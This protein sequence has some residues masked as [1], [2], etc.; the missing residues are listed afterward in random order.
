MQYFTSYQL[1]HQ[2][3]C[4][5][6]D[7]HHELVGL[8]IM[9]VANN[10][11][12]DWIVL[13]FL[14]AVWLPLGI[15]LLGQSSD[16][17]QILSRKKTNDLQ[18]A[19]IQPE[20][21]CN[22]ILCKVHWFCRLLWNTWICCVRCGTTWRPQV[23]TKVQERFEVPTDNWPQRK[24]KITTKLLYLV[25]HYKLN[26]FKKWFQ[27]SESFENPHESFGCGFL[28]VLFNVMSRG[29]TGALGLVP[30]GMQPNG[31]RLLGWLG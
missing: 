22:R 25:G 29:I 3:F 13:W 6:S 8:L 21:S 4:G 16:Q 18:K 31:T 14:E 2:I 10:L 9:E 30:T 27:E 20:V 15:N 11:H 28:V 5:Q 7:E 23:L 17:L 24:Q 26:R 12:H 19:V 1:Q